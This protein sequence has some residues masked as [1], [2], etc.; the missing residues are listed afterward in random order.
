MKDIA[1]NFWSLLQCIV[2]NMAI[3]GF[4]AYKRN[5]TPIT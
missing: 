4:I 1:M 3:V 5:M 2:R